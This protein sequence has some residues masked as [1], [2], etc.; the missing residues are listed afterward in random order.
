[1]NF[2]T[3]TSPSLSSVRFSPSGFSSALGSVKFPSLFPSAFVRKRYKVGIIFYILY[4]IVSNSFYDF[5]RSCCISCHHLC[6]NFNQPTLLNITN[7]IP[8]AEKYEDDKPIVGI[9]GGLLEYYFFMYDL[10]EKLNIQ[11]AN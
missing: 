2:F 11:S 5:L 6:L 10:I 7:S 4:S 3:T 8:E 1:M 9:A